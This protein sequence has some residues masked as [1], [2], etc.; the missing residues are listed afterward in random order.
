ME[1]DAAAAAATRA[2][3]EEG[4]FS[5]AAASTPKKQPPREADK[6]A[7]P[8]PAAPVTAPVTVSKNQKGTGCCG[9]GPSEDVVE[10]TSAQPAV[11]VQVQAGKIL[12]RG[13][14]GARRLG[15][16]FPHTHTPRHTHVAHGHHLF[17]HAPPVRLIS[18]AAVMVIGAALPVAI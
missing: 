1:A 4:T 13:C 2:E 9:L 10:P 6:P 15:W 3:L 14:F 16:K 11:S 5:E 8:A 17:L 18:L 12:T 7:V